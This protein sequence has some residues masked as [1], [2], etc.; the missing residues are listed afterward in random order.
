MPQSIEQPFA[1]GLHLSTELSLCFASSVARGQKEKSAKLSE[2]AKIITHFYPLGHVHH[3]A[4]TH[5]S[6]LMWVLALSCCL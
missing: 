5:S 4:L 1:E 3:T 6:L 2:S